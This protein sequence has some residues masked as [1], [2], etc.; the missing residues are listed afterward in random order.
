VWFNLPSVLA[1][2]WWITGRRLRSRLIDRFRIAA[3][4]ISPEAAAW[5]PTSATSWPCRGYLRAC[6]GLAP[7]IWTPPRCVLLLISS[8]LVSSS[9]PLSQFFLPLQV[10]Q[11]TT[12]LD[13]NL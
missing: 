4:W 2:G 11:A 3:A 8:P 13:K 6:R 7:P 10:E 1:Y 9:S 5:D 12:K